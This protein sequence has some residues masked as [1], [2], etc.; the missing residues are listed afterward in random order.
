MSEIAPDFPQVDFGSVYQDWPSKGFIYAYSR[1]DILGR[2]MRAILGLSEISGGKRV[3]L[4]FSHS[5][6]LRLGLTGR[7]FANGDYRIFRLVKGDG[8]VDIDLEH[9]DSTL[10]GGLG[11]SSTER[12]ELGSGL[13]EPEIPLD[14]GWAQ[15]NS[16]NA[17]L[18]SPRSG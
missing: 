8:F 12:V 2:A 13:P 3:I 1:V 5:G 10:K 11:L 6:F 7:W 15:F 16:A 18:N 9:N 4:V 17:K 14:Y